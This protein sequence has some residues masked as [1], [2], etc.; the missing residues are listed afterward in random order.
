M[1]K[2][3]PFRLDP[4]N[5]PFSIEI[6]PRFGDMDVNRHINNV[7]FARYFEEGRV[8]F[9]RENSSGEHFTGLRG[10]IVSVTINYLAEGSYPELITIG[11]GFGPAGNSSWQILLAAFQEDHCI[12]TCDSILAA[13]NEN[14]AHGI[15]DEWRALIAAQQVRVS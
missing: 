13:R 2:P 15:S 3:E 7:A 12:T 9:Q 11:A 14:G 6:P 8:R 10:F 1:A 4:T 5:Y